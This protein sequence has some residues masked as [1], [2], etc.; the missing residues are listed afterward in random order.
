MSS[1][2]PTIATHPRLL[3]HVLIV[4]LLFGAAALT[5]AVAGSRLWLPRQAAAAGRCPVLFRQTFETSYGPASMEFTGTTDCD[6]LRKL[7]SGHVEPAR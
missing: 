3:L 4:A 2:R 5:V 1:R 6:D 7:T